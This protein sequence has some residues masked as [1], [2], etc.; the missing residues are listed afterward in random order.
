MQL[1]IALWLFFC[2][3]LAD[4][5]WLSNSWMLRAKAKGTPV[6]PIIVH[7]GVHATLMTLVIS[8][9]MGLN[10]SFLLAFFSIQLLTHAVID[11]W[12]GRMNAWF[13]S[14]QS[15]AVKWHWIMFGIDQFFHA[16]VILYLAQYAFLSL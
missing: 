4:F 5:T 12:K 11:I 10:A 15:P 13:P 1:H 9:W 3:F 8:L 6:F 16:A 14:L 2:H 7:A